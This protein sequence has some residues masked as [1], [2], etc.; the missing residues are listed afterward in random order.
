MA[1]SK[2]VFSKQCEILGSLWL[3][4]REEAKGNQVWG[5]FFAWADISLPLAYVAWQG[6]ATIKSD[7]KSYVSEAW[8]VFCEMISIDANAK[9]ENL[10]EC[11]DASPNDD[12]ES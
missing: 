3:D 10:G 8:E 12:L 5:D 11:F 1:S 7:S 9:Y 4:Y 2:T 6:I